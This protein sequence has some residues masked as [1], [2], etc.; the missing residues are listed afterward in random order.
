LQKC[1]VALNQLPE[2]D[3]LHRRRGELGY[4]DDGDYGHGDIVI[5]VFGKDERGEYL[6]SI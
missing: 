1:L 3:V 4:D 6:V 2:D 5:Y